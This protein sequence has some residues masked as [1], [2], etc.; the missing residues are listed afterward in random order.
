MAHNDAENIIEIVGNAAGKSSDAF[1]FLS[2][3]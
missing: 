1:K 3:S 2:L